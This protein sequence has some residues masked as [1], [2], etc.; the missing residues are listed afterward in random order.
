MDGQT[1]GIVIAYSAFC[2][3]AVARQKVPFS[4]RGINL[5]S[6]VFLDRNIGEAAIALTK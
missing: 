5:L 4:Q 3:Y 1:D 6:Q 2:V